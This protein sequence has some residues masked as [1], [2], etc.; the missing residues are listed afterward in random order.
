VASLLFFAK[1]KLSIYYT[2]VC[3]ALWLVIPYPRY[4][5][6]NKFTKIESVEQFDEIVGEIK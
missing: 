1:F 4:N 2:V 3:L 5:G 6:A